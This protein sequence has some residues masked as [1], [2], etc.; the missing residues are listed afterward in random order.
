LKELLQRSAD[1]TILQSSCCLQTL[2]S[3]FKVLKAL[4]LHTVL[5]EKKKKK[6]KKKKKNH[7]HVTLSPTWARTPFAPIE[8]RETICEA[9]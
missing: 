2:Y 9:N 8:R 5:R 3:I 7:F 6:K 1:G 4:K